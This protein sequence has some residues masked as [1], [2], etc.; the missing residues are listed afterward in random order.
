MCSLE[1]IGGRQHLHIL[2]G[3]WLCSNAQGWTMRKIS[4]VWS[5][6]I[7]G[8][9]TI[10]LAILAMRPSEAEGGDRCHSLIDG[11]CLCFPSPSLSFL[12]RSTS[13]LSIASRH[14]QIKQASERASERNPGKHYRL[15]PAWH[16][17]AWYSTADIPEFLLLRAWLV[18]DQKRISFRLLMKRRASAIGTTMPIKRT[19]FDFLPSFPVGRWMKAKRTIVQV[20]SR[21]RER[22]KGGMRREEY[23]NWFSSSNFAV[24][25]S[26][27]WLE[28]RSRRRRRKISSFSKI[29]FLSFTSR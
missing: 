9:K 22:E 27:S 13:T 17:L 10:S 7:N 23:F 21:E 2:M 14:R 20:A 28:R 5:I 8:R 19:S 24:L 3:I 4:A 11:E 1:R 15:F 29:N 16:R 12:I 26:S 18:D 25:L 6:L